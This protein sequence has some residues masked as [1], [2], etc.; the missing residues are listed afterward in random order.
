MTMDEVQT[1]VQEVRLLVPRAAKFALERHGVQL[2][3]EK[4]PY[5]LHLAHV[6]EVLL[7]F[8]I[9]DPDLLAAAW[10]HDVIEDT[11]TTKEEIHV[12]FGLRVAELVDAVTNRPGGNR[13]S[14][15]AETYP[16]VR[17]TP[18]A[19]TLK[20]ADRIANTEFSV[21]KPM[22]SMYRKEY[23]GFIEALYVEGENG[24]MWTHLDELYRER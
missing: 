5:G 1:S 2:Y 12:L 14:R 10:L 17:A 19:T 11:Q 7:R 15:H 16:R 6:E 18:G 4:H 22:F 8:D 23:E 21:M 20:L 3:G 24:R 13:A 9:Y